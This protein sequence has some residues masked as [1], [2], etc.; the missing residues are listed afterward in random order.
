MKAQILNL[1]F[2]F[3]ANQNLIFSILRISSIL[4]WIFIIA[5]LL[6]NVF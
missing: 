3:A 2:W 5:Y 6:I 4:I 1:K